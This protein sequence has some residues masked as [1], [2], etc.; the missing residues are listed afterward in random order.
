MLRTE[1]AK[2]SFLKPLKMGLILKGEGK[3]AAPQHSSSIQIIRTIRVKVH[4]ELVIRK[5]QVVFSQGEI[6]SHPSTLFGLMKV[7]IS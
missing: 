2:G 5:I 3:I 6:V 7:G 4:R 1:F